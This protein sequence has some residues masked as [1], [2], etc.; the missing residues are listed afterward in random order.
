MSRGLVKKFWEIAQ[1]LSNYH[2]EQERAADNAVK[3][4]LYIDELERCVQ[5]VYY[6]NEGGHL[7]IVINGKTIVGKKEP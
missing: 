4:K 1:S 6:L 3:V 5:Q 2:L 7:E